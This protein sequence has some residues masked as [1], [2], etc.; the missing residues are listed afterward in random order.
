VKVLKLL[1]DEGLSRKE[2]S[3]VLAVALQNIAIQLEEARKAAL[4]AKVTY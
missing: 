3:L 1:A 2:A 4:K